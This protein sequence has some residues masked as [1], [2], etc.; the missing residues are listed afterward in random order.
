MSRSKLFVGA[1]HMVMLMVSFALPVAQLSFFCLFR[2]SVPILGLLPG[3]V[4]HT[5]YGEK[6]SE[7]KVKSERALERTTLI[8]LYTHTHT[9]TK[10][11]KITTFVEYHANFPSNSSGPSRVVAIVH[12]FRDFS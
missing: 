2:Q 4:Y 3:V 10:R 11:R 6:T 5:Y 1:D 7:V 9:P 12:V 8:P